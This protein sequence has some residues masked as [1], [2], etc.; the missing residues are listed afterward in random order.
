MQPY[1][2][3]VPD[4]YKI[5]VLPTINDSTTIKPSFQY[6]VVPT[7]MST[8]YQ[9][10]QINAAKMLNMPLS[11]LYNGY[12]N[13]GLGNYSTPLAELF[14]NTL[15]SKKYSAGARL[16]YQ[17]SSGNVALDNNLSVFAGYSNASADLFGKVFLHDSYLFAEGGVHGNTVYDYGYNTKHDT[18]LD[19]N[20]IRQNYDL[21]NIRA[22]IQ[23]F[24]NDSSR[25]GYHGETGYDYFHDR[26]NHEENHFN[27][28]TQFSQRFL[29]NLVGVKLFFD[30]LT[31]NKMLDSTGAVNTL[32]VCEPWIHIINEDYR[33]MLGVNATIDADMH[34]V[35]P[36]LYPIAEFQFNIVKNV[37]IPF[38]GISGQD[39]N[40]SYQSIASE[41]PFIRPNLLVQNSNDQFT[42]YGG[43]KG[44]LGSKASYILKFDGSQ[45]DHQYFYVNDST[46]ILQNQFTVVYDNVSQLN[47]N[48][49]VNYDLSS[50]WSFTAKI[51]YYKYSLSHLLYAWQKPAS[52]AIFS[53]KY[54]L[55]NKILI[56]LDILELGKRYALQ[57]K[58]LEPYK[59]IPGVL[60]FNL[61]AEYRYTKI[62]S[63]WIHLNNFTA[64]K[65][66]AWNQYPTQRFNM[67][68]GFGYSL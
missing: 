62:L 34:M 55:A 21:A 40:H 2:P 43:I 9:V 51:N 37:L 58:S 30:Q 36:R 22:G 60:D 19:K 10:S 44:S 4:A 49:D 59:V 54:N 8:E 48:L 12:L 33:L 47:V 57:Y 50:E 5:E 3:V 64:S 63:F 1:R 42:F 17:S 41:N 27:I 38:L 13:L 56:N 39:Y 29:K 28:N 45:I 23:S 20:N 11:K 67:M 52:D 14:L 46:T 31:H 26:F 35:H 32:F 7:M 53:A 25:L 15:R 66:Y 6:N 65:Y 68:V 61:S 18:L 24:H 16:D